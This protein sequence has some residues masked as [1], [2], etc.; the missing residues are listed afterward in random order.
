MRKGFYLLALLI[1]IF[2]FRSEAQGPMSEEAFMSEYR[3]AHERHDLE[4]AMKLVYWDGVGE[5]IKQNLRANFK[6]DFKLN[7]EKL[8]MIP[9]PK[10][11]VTQY[12][13]H[14]KTYRTNLD[15]KKV[16]V[17]HFKRQL[18]PS[19]INNTKYLI[20]VKDGKYYITTAVPVK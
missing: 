16:F 8:E 11:E 15:V 2:P 6:D 5:D 3:R 9:P 4:A 7:L 10:D 14:G 17:V 1:S 19:Q 12:T 20:G 18:G 13:L